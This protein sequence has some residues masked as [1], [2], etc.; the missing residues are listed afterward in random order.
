MVSEYRDILQYDE[1]TMNRRLLDYQTQYNQISSIVQA[2]RSLNVAV[3]VLIGLFL[4]TVFVVV[5]M[6]IRNFIFFLQNEVRIIELV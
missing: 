3:Y 6:V 5:H 4:F 2:L 1:T